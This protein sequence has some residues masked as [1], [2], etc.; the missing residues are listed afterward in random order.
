MRRCGSVILFLLFA[1]LVFAGI[2]YYAEMRARQKRQEVQPEE[3]L[4]IYTDL[5]QSALQ[6]FDRPYYKEFGAGLSITEMTPAQIVENAEKGTIPD[7]YLVSQHTL[8]KL[9]DMNML[10]VYASDRTDTVLNGCKDEDGYWTGVWMNPAVFAVNTDFA[11][12]HPAFFYTWDEVLSR[13]SVRLVMTDFISAD[14]SEESLISLTEHFGQKECFARLRSAAGHIVQYGKYLST[15]A[16]MAAMDKCDI[17][18]SGFNEVMRVKQDGL[19]VKIIY[20]EDG[21]FYYLYGA[22]LSAAEAR[23][24]E[25]QRFMDWILDSAARKP[26]LEKHGYYFLYVNETRLPED[27]ANMKIEFWPLEKKYTDEGKKDLLEQWLQQIRFG[28]DL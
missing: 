22:A 27:E 25:A 23:R 7:L 4:E 26:M 10:A 2:F 5:P 14:Y 8:D 11:L 20:P 13:Q 6:I 15:P 24:E 1:G 17:G 3:R 19:P 21:T 16:Q 18:I 9:K 12:T 28:K